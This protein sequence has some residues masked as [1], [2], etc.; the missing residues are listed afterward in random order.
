MRAWI[1]RLQPYGLLTLFALPALWPFTHPGFPRTNDNFLHYYRVVELDRLVRAGVLFPRWAPD[2]VHGYGYPVF[3]FFPYLSHYLAEIFHLLGPDFLTAFKAA[4]AA[5]LLCAAWFAYRLG[6]EHFGETPGLVAGVAYL[7]S[8]YL[9]Y[10]AHIRGALPEVTALAL[11]PL[12]MLYL[13]RAAQGD[14]R[15]VA[16]AGLAMGA[17]IFAHNAVSL[18]AMPLLGLYGLCEA[19]LASRRRPVETGRRP[20]SLFIRHFSF[21]ILSFV[22]ALLL[23]ASYWLPSLAE[24]KHVQFSNATSNSSMF[25]FT[26]FTPLRELLALPRL[27]VDPDLLNPPVIRSLPLAALVIASLSLLRLLFAPQTPKFSYFFFA[28]TTLLAVFLVLPASQP[29][30]DALPLLRLTLYPWRLLGFISLSIALLAGG[31]FR[32]HS[33]PAIRPLPSITL[34]LTISFLVIAGLPFASPPLEPAPIHP[35]LAD[36]AG[37]EIPPDLIGTSTAAEFLPVWVE[38]LPDT[39]PARTKLIHG[40][41]IDRFD[42]PPPGTVVNIAAEGGR[43]HAFTITAPQPFTFVYRTFYFPGWRARLDSQPVPVRITYPE[44]LMAVDVPAGDHALAFSFGATPPRVIGSAL[45][46]AGLLLCLWIVKPQGLRL[47]TQEAD[48]RLPASDAKFGAWLLGFGIFLALARPLVYD[49]GYTPLLRRGLMPEGLAGAA[50]LLNQDFAGELTLLGWDADRETIVADDPVTV[51]LYWKANHRLG[52]AYGFQLRLVDADGLTWSEGDT[53]R[54]RDWRFTPGTDFW[55]DDQYIMESYVLTP[56][57]GAPPGEYFVEANVFAYYNLQSIGAARVGPVTI[58]APSRKRLCRDAGEA[59]FDRLGALV[60]Q[61]AG[62]SSPQA[63]PGNDITASLC[64]S[65]LSPPSADLRGE[66]RLL[67]AAGKARVTHPFTI[68]GRY[69]TSLWEAADTIRDR[70]VVRLPAALET[71]EYT[72]TLAASGK[73]Q[74]VGSLLITAPDRTFA[75]PPVERALNVNLGPVTLFGTNLTPTD[76]APG[77]PMSVMLVWKGNQTISAS[78]YHVFVH[79]LSPEGALLAQSDGVPADRT[80]PTTGWLPGEFVSETRTLN[81]PADLQPGTYTLFAGMYLPATG[82]RLVTE[83]FPDGR[84]PLGMVRV[85]P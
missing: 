73:A 5:A 12:T 66:L 33:S 26:H 69:P 63:A 79:L 83:A 77:Q 10:N 58:N 52:V 40:E 49:A 23:S 25:Y 27:P 38:K 29:V 19:W 24:I 14:D 21:V 61:E 6:R 11:L 64:W 28:A 47:K 42:S 37:F 2:L 72:W 39:L 71:G 31:L 35:T 8:P 74:S 75:A 18:Q 32:S 45:S 13:R 20:V 9:L 70:V 57:A 80:R 62:F 84:V 41:E 54:P 43:G 81:L 60:L 3:N 16:W 50:H 1:R 85:G 15:A 51:N 46:W 7:Y 67:D 68:G 65:V 56:L 59:G 22:I 48:F 30:W 55:P 76:A 44:G 36:V 82:D 53:P 17:F 4:Y 34:P 78:G